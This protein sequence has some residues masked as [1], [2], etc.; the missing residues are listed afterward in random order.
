MSCF[1]SKDQQ[2]ILERFEFWKRNPKFW[3]FERAEENLFH[4]RLKKKEIENPCYVCLHDPDKDGKVEEFYH[5]D[6]YTHYLRVKEHTI[7]LCCQFSK[8]QGLLV[9]RHSNR[10]LLPERK[11]P[12]EEEDFVLDPETEL[13]RLE[14][15]L[16]K[17]FSDQYAKSPDERIRLATFVADYREWSK[18][19]FLCSHTDLTNYIREYLEEKVKIQERM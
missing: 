9:F 4:L 3:K 19:K 12:E 6:L 7:R 5:Y 10:T 11:Q 15:D 17:Y 13:K 2:F 18:Y 14:K 8:G 1:S 16:K